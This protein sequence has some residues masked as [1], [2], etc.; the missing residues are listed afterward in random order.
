MGVNGKDEIKNHEFFRGLDW[1]KLYRKE[2]E[3]PINLNDY[4]VDI[5][6]SSSTYKKEDAEDQQTAKIF[7]DID[8]TETNSDLNRVR[9]FTFVRSPKAESFSEEIA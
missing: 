4:K 7:K 8:Y 9:N 5:N 6:E 3:L 2:I 1:D